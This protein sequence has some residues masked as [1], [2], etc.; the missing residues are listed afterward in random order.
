[1]WLL[2]VTA[3]KG[4]RK[5]SRLSWKSK[6]YLG[7]CHRHSLFT[8]GKKKK[9]KKLRCCGCLRFI[10]KENLLMFTHNTTERKTIKSELN[11]TTSKY[12]WPATLL[13]RTIVGCV[14]VKKKIVLV[15]LK[16]EM[17][18]LL[19]WVC[20]QTIKITG[21]VGQHW[22]NFWNYCLLTEKWSYIFSLFRGNFSISGPRTS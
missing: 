6:T 5:V 9:K 1:M 19:T 22:E 3:E 16:E 20:S 14:H 2:L 11:H 17:T 4:C 12:S 8:N 13:T 18:T 10:L 15:P 7:V 21:L